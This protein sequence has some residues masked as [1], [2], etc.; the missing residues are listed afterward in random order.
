MPSLFNV[1]ELAS[2]LVDSLGN[3]ADDLFTSDEERKKAVLAIRS[4]LLRHKEKLAIER[5]QT[6]RSETSGHWYQRAWRPLMMLLFGVVIA[7][8]WFGLAGQNVTP[9]VQ[10]YL[11]RIIQLGIGGYV[12]GRSAEK[13]APSISDAIKN[14]N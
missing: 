5:A 2:D 9:E 14:R 8:H 13:I 6:V 1:G 3:V 10:A 4:R 11:Y 7:S 12:V